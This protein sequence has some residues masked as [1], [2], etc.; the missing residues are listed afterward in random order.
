MKKK[1]IK[2]L[3]LSMAAALAVTSAAFAAVTL[4]SDVAGSQN[5]NLKK[6][7]EGLMEA[8]AV[9]GDEDGL[10]HPE[11][12]LTRAQVC[13]M[14]VTL[15]EPIALHGTPTRPVEENFS[16]MSGYSWAKSYVSY[17]ADNGIAKGYGDNKF[18][19]GNNVTIAELATFTLRACGYT[20]EQLGGTWPQNYIDKAQELKLFTEQADTGIS[21]NTAAELSKTEATKAQAATVIY[22]AMDKIKRD[23]A[24][25]Q[26]QGTYNDRA[27]EAPSVA[28]MV[29]ATGKFNDSMTTYDGKELA[30]DV[31]VYSYGEKKDY[32]RDMKL[33]SSTNEY[34]MT[35][36]LK[37]KGV[38]TPAWYKLESGKI[39][40]IIVPADTG[41]TGKIYCV[42]NSANARTLNANG[43]SVKGIETLTAMSEITWFAKK[44]LIRL[45]STEFLNGQVYELTARDGEITNVA[46]TTGYKGKKFEELSGNA[47]ATVLD[48]SDGLVKIKKTDTTEIWVD[49]ND[50]ASVYKLNDKSNGYET[51][52]LSQVK[53][54]AEVRLYDIS[55]NDENLADIV[56]IK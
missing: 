5:E 50:S 7:V 52:R 46:T 20:D 25:S 11:Q 12:K 54:G 34:R 29:Y 10:F 38:S 37:Y 51:G 47:W 19:P 32:S 43:D 31:A 33:P 26:P 39:T 13:K 23:T 6:A 14:I 28:S 48:K 16:D 35:T 55:D 53:K 22:N 21:Y 44:D 45:S 30:K 40:E 41:F 1:I 24:E 27:G 17:A 9:T 36:V 49:I 2:I 18:K 4:P 56:V 42:I 8:G 3:A 15:A